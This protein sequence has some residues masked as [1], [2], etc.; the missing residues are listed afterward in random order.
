MKPP[1]VATIITRLEGGAGM[2][3]F[4]GARATGHSGYEQTIITGSGNGLI[5]AAR[6]AGLEVIVEPSLRAPIAPRSDATALRRLGALL[7]QREFDV[8]HTHCAKAGALGRLAAHR[9][10]AP[11]IVHTYHGFPF[12]EFQSPVRRRA[13]MAAERW[14]GRFT[15]I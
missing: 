2:L 1:R 13:Y 15:D 7:R 11:K 10:G 3:A 9:A 12:H 5:A 8:V 4:R 6:D 14:L